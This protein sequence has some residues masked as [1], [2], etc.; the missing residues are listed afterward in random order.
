ML[1]TSVLGPSQ[2]AHNEHILHAHLS[3][4]WDAD[5]ASQKLY[6]KRALCMRVVQHIEAERR[7]LAKERVREY[8]DYGGPAGI[9][10]KSAARGSL[11]IHGAA[12][13][14]GFPDQQMARGARPALP[15]GCR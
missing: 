11:A 3:V 13:F 7:T 1:S 5:Y 10:R 2:D 15:A 4:H 12:C 8:G 14:K 6:M 9:L